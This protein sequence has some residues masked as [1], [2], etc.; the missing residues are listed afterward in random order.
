MHAC[1]GIDDRAREELF[2]LDRLGLLDA[3]TVLVHGLAFD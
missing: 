1:E 3:D 2:K